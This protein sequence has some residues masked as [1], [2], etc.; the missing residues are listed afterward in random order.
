[1]IAPKNNPRNESDHLQQEFV[2]LGLDLRQVW[3]STPEEPAV[4]VSQLRSL[5][6]WVQAYRNGMDRMQMVAQ[7]FISPPIFPEFDEDSDWVRFERW[8]EGDCL[9]WTYAD[10]FGELPDPDNLDD[11]QLWATFVS[12]RTQLATRRVWIDIM[13]NVPPRMLY[14]LVRSELRGR[15]FWHTAPGTVNRIGCSTYCPGCVQRPWCAMGRLESW[16]EDEASGSMAIP[17]SAIAF[18]HRDLSEQV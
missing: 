15:V 3:H 17:D 7:G 11:R 10:E 14:E 18:V 4:E 9:T 16:P 13:G 6:D 1:M 2:R 8:M 5:L 12:V